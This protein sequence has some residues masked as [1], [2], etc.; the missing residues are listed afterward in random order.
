MVIGGLL[1]SIAF[2]QL[3]SGMDESCD[4]AKLLLQDGKHSVIINFVGCVNESNKP[5]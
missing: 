3:V 2:E 1:K 4:Q 5:L